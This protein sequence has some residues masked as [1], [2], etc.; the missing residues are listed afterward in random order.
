[1]TE[2]HPTDRP[3]GPPAAPDGAVEEITG[4]DQG[5]AYV[6]TVLARLV[7]DRAEAADLIRARARA[8]AADEARAQALAHVVGEA[9]RAALLADTARAAARLRVAEA[10]RAVLPLRASAA[11][12]RALLDVAFTTAR[13]TERALGDLLPEGPAR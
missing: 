7:A 6:E 8:T 10:A 13:A 12:V 11:E 2:P 9:V 1:M 4:W 5:L 3:G